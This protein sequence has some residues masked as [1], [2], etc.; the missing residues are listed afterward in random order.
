MLHQFDIGMF[1]EILMSPLLLVSPVAVVGLVNNQAPIH[2]AL[3]IF[4]L[5]GEAR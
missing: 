2:H 5:E 1:L 3:D 4:K